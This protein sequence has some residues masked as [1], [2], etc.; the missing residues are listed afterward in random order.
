MCACRIDLR[1]YHQALDEGDELIAAATASKDK[2]NIRKLQW[3]TIARK[4]IK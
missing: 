4:P 1:T 2:K 3:D